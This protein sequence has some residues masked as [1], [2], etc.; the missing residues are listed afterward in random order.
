V[1]DR[2]KN[3]VTTEPPPHPHPAPPE[4]LVVPAPPAVPGH[5]TEISELRDEVRKARRAT[6]QLL[7]AFKTLRREV[8]DRASSSLHGMAELQAACQDLDDR[9]EQIDGR[10]AQL[11][12]KI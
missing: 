6:Q 7:D 1:S 9:L 4:P 11:Q 2:P 3:E 12:A 10:V 5:L 8:T